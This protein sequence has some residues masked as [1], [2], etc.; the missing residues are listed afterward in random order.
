MI[1]SVAGVLV[2]GAGIALLALDA[3][4]ERG[5]HDETEWTNRAAAHEL[6]DRWIPR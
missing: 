2:A 1:E 3:R 6:G 4:R 5:W